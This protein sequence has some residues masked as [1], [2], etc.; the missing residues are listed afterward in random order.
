MAVDKK[1]LIE[2]PTEHQKKYMAVVAAQNIDDIILD[3][4]KAGTI[5]DEA[6]TQAV[7]LKEVLL[8]KVYALGDKSY[9]NDFASVSVQTR[10]NP[11]RID[12][13]K[14]IAAGVD[15][16]VIDACTIPGGESDA[17]VVVRAAKVKL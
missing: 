12:R 15:P 6:E 13:T 7:L 4:L 16:D 10:K 2:H 9:R 11:D 1:Q 3:V 8:Q 5:A 14:L 17:F